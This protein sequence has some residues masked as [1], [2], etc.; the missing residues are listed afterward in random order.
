MI[1]EVEPNQFFNDFIE[2]KRQ[3][4]LAKGH[5]GI[6]NAHFN[7]R[8]IQIKGKAPP[9]QAIRIEILNYDF[10]STEFCEIEYTYFMGDLKK[11]KMAVLADEWK[12][13]QFHYKVN[14]FTTASDLYVFALSPSITW[15][16]S[17]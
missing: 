12:A 6:Y 13:F 3:C 11:P 4:G 14:S 1:S 10:V 15:W 17:T 7:E 9:I 8:I 16:Q 2:V 5:D